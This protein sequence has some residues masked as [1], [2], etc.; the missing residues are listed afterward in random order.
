METRALLV[1][2]LLVPITALDPQFMG[3]SITYKLH[4]QPGGDVVVKLTTTHL[5]V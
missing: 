1:V 4:Q 5:Y 3:G 2:A